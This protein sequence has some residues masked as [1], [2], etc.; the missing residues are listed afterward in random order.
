MTWALEKVLYIGSLFIGS[1]GLTIFK[2]RH[3]RQAL[4]VSRHFTSIK[5]FSGL[6]YSLSPAKH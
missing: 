5:F 6:V 4:L 2:F 1:P 3:K